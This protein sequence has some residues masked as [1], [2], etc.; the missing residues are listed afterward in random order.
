MAAIGSRRCPA[1]YGRNPFW[2]QAC[3]S[4]SP[5][6]CSAWC[7][8]RRAIT[9][10]PLR[11]P[12]LPRTPLSTDLAGRAHRRRRISQRRTC[13]FRHRRPRRVRRPHRTR[14]PTTPGARRRTP[15]HRRSTALA[16][17]RGRARPPTTAPSPVPR[18]QVAGT[19]PDTPG[20]GDGLGTGNGQRPGIATVYRAP[21]DPSHPSASLGEL[22][23]TLCGSRCLTARGAFRLSLGH[24]VHDA[25]SRRPVSGIALARIQ[26]HRLER[27]PAPAEEDS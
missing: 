25:R 15:R 21:L 1:G 8:R 23:P 4:G 5:W 18:T 22:Q 9:V 17:C 10:S 13:W 19:A 24:A 11:P 3:S 16:R 2:R 14:L 27:R 7:C 6:S 12:T 26:C 20:S